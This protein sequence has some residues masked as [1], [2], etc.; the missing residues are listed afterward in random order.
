VRRVELGINDGV[1]VQVKSGLSD[2]ELVITDGQLHVHHGQ[3]V[4]IVQ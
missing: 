2:H 1:R 3:Q 4:E